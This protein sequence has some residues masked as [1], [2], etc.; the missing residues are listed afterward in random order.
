MKDS[1]KEDY[2][3]QSLSLDRELT[4]ENVRF[5][6]GP[7]LP[8]VL[9]NASVSI[10]SGSYVC[11]LGLSGG[12]KSTLLS[13]LT[14]TRACTSGRILMDGVDI[15][16]VPLQCLRD[17]L[18][19]V[20]QETFV[21]DGTIFDN[22]SFGCTDSA[23]DLD[24]GRE[25]VVLAAQEAGIREF[26]ES[27]P[28][29]Y[30]TVIGKEGKISLSGGQLQQIC[31]VARALAR[32]PKLLILDE[33]TN[34]LDKL[35]ELLIIK[36]IERLRDSGLTIVS[37]THHPATATHADNI[38]VLDDGVIAQRGTYNDL[39]DQEGLFSSLIQAERRRSDNDEGGDR[40]DAVN[41]R[42][43]S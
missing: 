12:G 18:A 24:Q 42:E 41:E 19:V 14:G 17:S 1:E 15:S 32:K 40:S 39:C 11:F 29:K 33:A 9:K 23:D 16:T 8:V 10:A 13:L 26:I 28:E 27:L 31:G 6:Y 4:L 20:F 7:N 3:L 5:L 21:L 35:S 25:I 36:T 38:I 43:D 34:S 30:D 2:K 37:F 22:I